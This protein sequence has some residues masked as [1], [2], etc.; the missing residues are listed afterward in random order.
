[1][2]PFE[3]L[4]AII[5]IVTAGGVL[6]S[7]ISTIG[8]VLSSRAASRELPG[9]SPRVGSSGDDE[10]TREAIDSVRGRLERLEE[11]RDF[12]KDLLDAPARHRELGPP[13]TEEN[14]R[15]HPDSPESKTRRA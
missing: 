12:Y 10:A 9:E 14:A 8:K 5:M 11:E 6:T 3:A 1:M 13:V 2:N 7:L 15:D 4:V